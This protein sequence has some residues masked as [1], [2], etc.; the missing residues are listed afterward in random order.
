M[1]VYKLYHRTKGSFFHFDE[2]DAGDDR[3]AR[4]LAQA[5]R[6]D[7]EC[8]LWQGRRRVEVYPA[9]AGTGDARR[10]SALRS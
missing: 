7:L 3:E 8:E 5:L 4:R 6:G 10:A 1:A 9:S 2:I